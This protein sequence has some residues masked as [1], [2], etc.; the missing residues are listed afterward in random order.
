[1]KNR[2]SV[3]KTLPPCS[4]KARVDVTRVD[5]WQRSYLGIV[6]DSYS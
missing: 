5:G 2:T 3:L 6:K 4:A 1:M